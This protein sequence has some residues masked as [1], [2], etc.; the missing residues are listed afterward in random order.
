MKLPSGVLGLSSYRESGVTLIEV[1]IAVLVLAIG[2]VG[3]MR[4]QGIAKQSNFEALQRT[5]AVFIAKDMLEK[6][7]A[8]RSSAGVLDQYKGSYSGQSESKPSTSCFG[9]SGCNVDNLVNW[10]RYQFDQAIFGASHTLNGSSVGSMIDAKGCI[11]VKDGLVT[12][13][14]VWKG[15]PISHPAALPDGVSDC[16]GHIPDEAKRR[17]YVLK[18]YIGV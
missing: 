17:S 10:D 4:M 14:L 12:I 1:L 7:E 18:T 15:L 6:M 9:G 2:F 5:Q 13:A 3:T 11:H 16:A 8:N